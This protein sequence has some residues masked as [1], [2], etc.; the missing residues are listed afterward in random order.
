MLDSQP[1]AQPSFK[2]GSDD[3]METV[4]VQ[5]LAAFVDD[6]HDVIAEA[7][8]A[9]DIA[10]PQQPPQQPQPLPQPPQQPPQQ[11]QPLPQPP[12]QPPPQP[13][14]QPSPQPQQQLPKHL[15]EKKKPRQQRGPRVYKAFKKVD[16]ETDCG[17][18]HCRLKIADLK[19]N[20]KMVY[21]RLYHRFRIR[22]EELTH[23]YQE[24]KE[25]RDYYKS[26]SPFP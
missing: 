11:P 12:Q 19:I 6:N 22:Y 25:E 23:D 7:M 4:A 14:P 15:T 18:L 24:M 1:K 20:H 16:Y 2:S 10:P 17:C 5:D 8:R 13:S 26:I 21:D 9:A 3:V